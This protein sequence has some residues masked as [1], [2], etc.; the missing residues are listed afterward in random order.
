[1]QMDLSIIYL[2]SGQQ[3]VLSHEVEKIAKGYTIGYLPGWV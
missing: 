2:F 1:M 3:D